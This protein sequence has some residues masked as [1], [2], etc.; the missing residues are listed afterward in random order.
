MTISP[1]LFGRKIESV[2]IYDVTGREVYSE[3]SGTSNS[4]REIIIDVSKFPVG[5]Y[6]VQVQSADIISMKKLVVEK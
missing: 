5:V 1:D 6:S 4:N 3:N 2:A